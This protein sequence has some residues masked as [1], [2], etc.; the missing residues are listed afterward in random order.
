MSSRRVNRRL[1]DVGHTHHVQGVEYGSEGITQLVPEHGQKL[2]LAPIGIANLTVEPRVIDEFGG[3]A[4][5][6]LHQASLARGGER[7]CES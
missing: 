3:L 7:G 1:L 2:P 5:V 4:D 6:K